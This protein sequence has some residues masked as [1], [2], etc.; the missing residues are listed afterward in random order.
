MRMCKL[1]LKIMFV[2]KINEKTKKECKAAVMCADTADT[3]IPNQE[4]ADELHKSIIRKFQK[5]DTY[6]SFYGLQ[7]GCSYVCCYAC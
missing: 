3:T 6:S 7:L 4:L 5:H 1:L 2:F